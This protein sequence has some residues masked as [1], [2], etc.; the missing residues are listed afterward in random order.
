M[1]ATPLQT[2]IEHGPWPIDGGM[3]G[4]LEARGYD[5]RS[6]LWSARLLADDPDAIRDVHL[7]YFRSGARVA[8]TASYQ[9]SRSGFA[10]AGIPADEADRLLTL[11]VELARSARDEALAAGISGPL[12]VA[13]SV[14]PYG[15]TLHDGS[16]YRGQ[17]GVTHDFLVAFHRERLAVLAAAGPDLFAV[18]TIPDA[19][20]AAALVD[21]LAEHP[22]IPAWLAYSCSDAGHT[23]G[24]DD[25][26]SAVRVAA[27]APSVF[28]VGVNC[29][30][31]QH[32]TGILMAM[33]EATDLPLV[34]YPNAG[35]T[36]D[37]STGLWSEEGIGLLAAS[38][39]AEW[40]DHGALLIGGCCGLGPAAI[41]DLCETLT[42]NAR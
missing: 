18:E 23:C 42:S 38:T 39:T 7:T 25:I 30:A 36:W 34:A 5:L 31:P 1:T 22:D 14:G 41:S 20:E 21:A 8:I 2:L 35:A 3:A 11:S 4:E 6:D 24:G 27:A 16:E 26:A 29:T 33:Q 28:A 32:V 15:A 37:A 12:F 19:F 40:V 10:A 13:A 17:Y 9:A